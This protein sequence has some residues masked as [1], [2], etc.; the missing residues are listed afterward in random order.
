MYSVMLTILRDTVRCLSQTMPN[1]LVVTLCDAFS[2]LM[3]QTP[4][5]HTVRVGIKHRGCIQFAYV[6]NTA[7]AYSSRMYQTTRLH[8]LRV[9][10]KRRGCIH[11]AYVS[12]TAAAYISL[13]YQTPRLH[14]VRSFIKQLSYK[15]IKGLKIM[16]KD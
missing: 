9:C 5:L 10:I 2:S 14:T 6:S 1:T 3:Y 4:R 16:V 11:F 15:K 13:M 7:D 8:T 12:N